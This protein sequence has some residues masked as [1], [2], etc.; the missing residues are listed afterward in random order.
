[1]PVAPTDSPSDDASGLGDLGLGPAPRA[2]ATLGALWL[3]VFTAASQT[4]VITPVLP[5]IGDALDV[6]PDVLGTLVQVYSWALAGAALVMGPISDRIGRR[7]VLLLGSGA[8]TG[9]LALHGLAGSFEAL[10]GARLLAGA[11]GGMLSGAAVSYVGDA[12]PYRRRG[13]ATGIVMSGIPVGLVLGV[14]VGRVLAAGLDFRVPFLAFAALMGAAFFLVLAVVP[15][16]NVRLDESRLDLR[17]YVSGYARL[18]AEAGTRAAA[19]TYFLMYLSLGLF[20][21]FLP[22]WITDTQPL[23]VHLFGEPLALGGLPVDFIAALF[24]VGGLASVVIG[25]WAGGLSDRA[26]RKPI[27]LASCVGLIVVTASVTYVVGDARW[28]LY[29]IYVAVMGLFALRA[30]PLQALLTALVPGRQRGTLMSFVIAIGQI[31]TGAGA[32]MAGLL[33]AGLGFRAVTFVSAATVVAMAVVV[34][35]A[36]PEPTSDPLDPRPRREPTADP[37]PVAAR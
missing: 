37:E 12:V 28:V 7:R 21:A 22:Q 6:G 1:M 5:V 33:Y 31:G 25:P 32:L 9:A 2:A 14:P 13:W 11:C 10:L 3:L 24:S 18:L 4:I 20:I 16:P 15:Q 35:R 30:S 36:L 19:L 29:P 34:W 27:I 8:M 23:D 26:G 17:E